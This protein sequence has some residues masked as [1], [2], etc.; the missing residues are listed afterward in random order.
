[1]E[2]QNKPKSKKKLIIVIVAAA[3]LLAVLVSA[4][5][6]FLM[7]Q[8]NLKRMQNPDE[9][10]TQSSSSGSVSQNADQA[11]LSD[12]EKVGKQITGNRCT[13][14][15]VPYK[16]SVAPM[17]SEDFGFVIPY[18]LMVGGHVTPVD[19]QY[20]TPADFRSPINSYEVRA[21]ADST[22]VSIQPRQETNP[23]THQQY[24]EYRFVFT[25][26][27]TYMYYY[28]LV[29][30]LA[31]D[32]QKV[33][34]ANGNSANNT[35]VN[36]PV[37]AGQVIGKIGGQTL[38]FAV[39]DTT[40]P[41]TGFVTPSNYDGEAWKIYTADPLNYYTDE[42][43]ATILS[44]YVRTAEPLSGKI[45]YDV[46]G[47]LIGT[48]FVE[49]SGGYRAMG[50]QQQDYFSGH[51]VFAPFL[52]DPSHFVVSI[53]SLY[54]KV[55]NETNMQHM[56]VGNMPDPKDVGVETGLVKY[57]LAPWQLLKSDGS[58]WD[59]MKYTSGGVTAST[60]GQQIFGCAA[61]QMTEARK[62]KFEVFVGKQC[63]NVTGFDD[64]AK[65]Y[66]R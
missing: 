56:V 12:A 1:V 52:Y 39:W 35:G 54:G 6:L 60:S 15:G 30:S 29:T 7:H 25:I 48:W 14:T 41:L 62:L 42:L 26:T 57:D 43:K 53:G 23:N 49:G 58:P 4:V 32:I 65:V 11:G 18:G 3:I 27:C 10:K 51:L 66:T 38:D 36:I 61:V 24:T 37:K 47:K 2:D 33:Y 28:D 45:D 20:F 17:K 21:M 46:D 5:A 40:K 9:A 16:L 8:S 13:G 44:R 64:S 63:K 55:Q 50:N 31:P 59:E 34:D 19:H 22:I